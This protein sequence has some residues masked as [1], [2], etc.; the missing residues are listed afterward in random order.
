MAISRAVVPSRYDIS[1]VFDIPNRTYSGTTTISFTVNSPSPFAELHATDP[2][3]NIQVSQS[4]SPLQ[5]THDS[6]ILRIFSSDFATPIQ[7]TFNGVISTKS[8]GITSYDGTH[9]SSQFQ[10]IFARTAFPCFDVP[11]VRST[12]K[13]TLTIPSDQTAVSNYPLESRVES[14]TTAVCSFALTAPMPVYL[15][16][17]A[18]DHFDVR[19]TETARGLPVQIFART[20]GLPGLLRDMVDHAN[21]AARAID[22][23]EAYFGIVLPI[24]EMHIAICDKFAVLGME[25]FG[26]VILESLNCSYELSVHEL[27]H[28]WAGDLTSVRNWNDL[29][30]NE[31]FA[32][33]FPWYF[34]RQ[35]D[36]EFFGETTTAVLERVLKEDRLP[37]TK[38]VWLETFGDPEECLD[39]LRCYMKAGLIQRMMRNYLGLDTFQAAV[40]AYFKEFYMGSGGTDDLVNVYSR[41]KDCRFLYGWLKQPGYPVLIL[42]EGRI[43][44]AP[45]SGDAVN[46]CLN[47]I[48]P[49]DVRY[50]VGGSVVDEQLL[51]GSE[52]VE[53]AK[54]A[55]WVC[56]NWDLETPCRVWHKG[57]FH[58]ALVAA[59]GKGKLEK[60]VVERLKS[61]LAWLVGMGVAPERMLADF[62]GK[63]PPR[64]GARVIPDSRLG[65]F[66][67]LD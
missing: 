38:P 8:P 63:S 33:M 22:Y 9:V 16:A 36:E 26:L 3:T 39:F 17:L 31:G 35:D 4:D 41:F 45:A 19:S 2:L 32:T 67:V 46:D 59:V 64:D 49:V 13:L 54:E 34:L 56:L 30:I 10:T 60:A 65:R 57:R 12:F 47:W 1:L 42:E 24:P 5:H 25:N 40:S 29:W 28:H 51:I 48:V 66:A 6:G 21:V 23:F 61:D 20:H 11:D 58:E 50:E 52:P 14:G 62:G 37:D 53:L 27:V 44:Q 7:I 15:L 18:I 43:C 55:D